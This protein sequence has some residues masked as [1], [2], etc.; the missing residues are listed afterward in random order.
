MTQRVWVAVSVCGVA[1][2]PR[3][4]LTRLR[5][6]ASGSR[7][8]SANRARASAPSKRVGRK[9]SSVAV[10]PEIAEE[11]GIGHPVQQGTGRVGGTGGVGVGGVH[12]GAAGRQGQDVTGGPLHP[13][14]DGAGGPGG[15]LHVAVAPPPEAVVE[16]T[17][18]VG[19]GH[20][21]LGAVDDDERGQH[22]GAGGGV[23]DTQGTGEVEGDDAGPAAGVDPGREPVDGDRGDRPRRHRVGGGGVLGEDGVPG[24]VLG[25]LPHEDGRPA[26]FVGSMGHASS[27]DEWEGGSVTWWLISGSKSHRTAS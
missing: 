6:D 16:L 24:P 10:A 27:I 17:G 15:P 12:G 25:G 19:P 9:R 2:L 23:G 8:T 20:H 26:L 22:A 3:S 7:S 4:T 1:V 18:G 14:R 13:A 11:G 5:R 21:R